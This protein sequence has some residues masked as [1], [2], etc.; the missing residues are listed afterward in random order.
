M[1][2]QPQVLLSINTARSRLNLAGVRAT[3]YEV[4]TARGSPR[5]HSHGTRIASRI[6]SACIVDAILHIHSL[7]RRPTLAAPGNLV[8]A[9]RVG[10][11]DAS[12]RDSE[13][14]VLRV[15]AERD[16][17]GRWRREAGC[18]R[19]HGDGRGR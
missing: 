9:A 12:S 6:D 3:I 16:R 1:Q 13:D 19:R 2:R 17:K 18:S 14:A 5:R 8:E 15:D 10:T 7:Q 4:P 11:A